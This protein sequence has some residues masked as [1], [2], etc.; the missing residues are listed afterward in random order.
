MAA[1][2]HPHGSPV[3][4][5]WGAD[6]TYQTFIKS[7]DWRKRHPEFLLRSGYRC[8]LLPWIRCGRVRG[9]YY[10]YNCHH[11]NY[12]HLQSERYGRD[13]LIVSPFAHRV[14]I[15]GVLS[16][17]K[18]AAEQRHY[19]NTPQRIVHLFCRL[20]VPVKF[21]AYVIAIGVIAFIISNLFSRIF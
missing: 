16:G 7:N 14:I 5:G 12:R 6:M 11:T 4:G 10:R 15:H 21:A 1:S 13:V 2:C 18:R 17:F 8:A 3:A 20:P 19:P 9:K